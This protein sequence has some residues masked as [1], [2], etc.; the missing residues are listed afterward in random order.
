MSSKKAKMP[1]SQSVSAV[2]TIKKR[3]HSQVEDGKKSLFYVIYFDKNVNIG[4]FY[5]FVYFIIY[6]IFFYCRTTRFINKESHR[7]SLT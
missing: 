4:V 3:K 7:D 1:R 5:L 6:N 2:D